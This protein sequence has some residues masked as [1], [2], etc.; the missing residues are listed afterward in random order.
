MSSDI[1]SSQ[2]ERRVDVVNNIKKCAPTQCKSRRINQE[3]RNDTK[4]S[5]QINYATLLFE[6]RM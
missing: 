4:V 3:A 6:V 2:V 1:G 5:E